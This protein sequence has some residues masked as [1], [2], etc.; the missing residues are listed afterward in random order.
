MILARLLICL[1]CL[2][3]FCFSFLLLVSASRKPENALWLLFPIFG[4]IP[5][6]LGA[7]LIF[8]PIEIYLSARALGHLKNVA[9]PMAGA[10][11]I[12][13]FMVVASIVTGNPL[14]YFSRI[15]KEGM[16]I[17]GP[18]LFWSVLGAIWGALWRLSDYLLG[19]VGLTSN[20]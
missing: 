5:V 10:L 15:S 18:I 7:L 9:I 3:L 1:V 6:V 14:K 13:I 2:A 8:V 17:V 12:V 16:H 4:G 19:A 20:E 11:L